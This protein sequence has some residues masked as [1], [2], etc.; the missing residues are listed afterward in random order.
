MNDLPEVSIIIPA[1]NAED[2]LDETIRSVLCQTYKHWQLF[3]IIDGAT[4]STAAIAKKY[5]DDLRI[6]IIEKSNT[7]VSDSRNIGIKAST[8]EWIALLDADD[9]WLPENL[10]RKINI[11]L[12]EQA[13]WVYSDYAELFPNGEE[14]EKIHRLPSDPLRS[15][16]RWE[17]Q[18]VTAPSGIVFNRKCFD[19]GCRFDT[20]FSTAADQDF[21]FQLASTCKVSHVSEIL[22]KYRV[23]AN[24]MSRNI[25]KM[26]SDHIGV[27]RKARKNGL[28]KRVVFRKFCFANLYLILAGSWWKNGGNKTKSMIYVVKSFFTHPSPLI[29]K[30]LC[31]KR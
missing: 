17:G 4:D 11:L 15:L 7:G 13:D 8:G 29:K 19:E 26:Q 10:K 22:W 12:T 16:L 30:I 9:V 20:S 27:Y 6:H 28:F 3:I 5:L 23:L 2:Y 14:I 25:Y 31:R 1:Y 21:C 24:S 18:V